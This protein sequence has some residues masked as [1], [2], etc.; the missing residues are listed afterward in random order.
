[1]WKHFST[2]CAIPRISKQE[3]ALR[4][5]L[6]DWAVGQGLET[7][8][9]QAGNLLIRKPA[10][11]G[12][13]DRPGVILQAH[14]DMVCQVNEGVSHD[15]TK[16]P[17]LPVERDGW[18]VAEETTLGADN[19]IGVALA[20]AAL[21]D[22]ALSYPELEVLLTVDEEAGM[23]G[24]HGLAPGVLTGK[25]MLNLDT[26]QW[27]EFYLG[28]A[29]GCNVT[30]TRHCRTEALSDGYVVRRLGV[31]GLVGGHSGIDIHLGRGNA[32]K[33]LVRLLRRL[34][35][36]CD[37]RVAAMQGGSARN[38]LPR[39][40]WADIA[41]PEQAISAIEAV[42]ADQQ[43]LFRSELLGVDDGVTLTFRPGRAAVTINSDDQA[44]L[45]AALHAAPHGVRKMSVAFD[46]VVETSNNL[47]VIALADGVFSANVMVRSLRE[48]GAVL[49]ADEISCL[50]SLAGCQVTV[51]GEYPGWTPN[52]HS[53]LLAQCRE[54]Y[55]RD[56][57]AEA[58][59]QVIHAGLECGVIGA[60]YPDI[61]TVSFGP[62]ILGAHAPGER[63]EIASVEQAWRFL[64][65]ILAEI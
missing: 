40:A 34:K 33:L 24:A 60:K 44:D 38:A 59:V 2:L 7:A 22:D 65:A 16:D 58:K 42:L 46:K 8:I 31:S 49:L 35:Q 54:V 48:S 19:G 5:H 36:T 57:H 6:S 10:S 14:L 15:F 11:S 62:T 55:A 47:G 25:R 20:L 28:C 51:S 9:D 26:E 30:I 45:L 63:V 53:P 1:V 41:L 61:D 32:N 50:F 4:R 3:S 21:E 43:A 52:P 13:E 29:G 18:L 27:G 12:K 56:F 64:R 23:G 39:E 17:I 37:V